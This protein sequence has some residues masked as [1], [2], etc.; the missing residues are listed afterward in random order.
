MN[1]VCNFIIISSFQMK[2]MMIC[3]YLKEAFLYSIILNFINIPCS[4]TWIGSSIY[5]MYKLLEKISIHS[6]LTVIRSKA[7]YCCSKIKQAIFPLSVA[8]VNCT[9]LSNVTL[10]SPLEVICNRAF[11]NCVSLSNILLP[12]SITTIRS[13]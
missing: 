10:S 1:K 9:S 8:F 11:Y 13:N 2:S 3:N 4:V 12:P 6:S 5:Y 7:F